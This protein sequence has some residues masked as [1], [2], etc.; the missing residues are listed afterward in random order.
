MRASINRT[1]TDVG[2]LVCDPG[3][4]RVYE[5]GWQSWSPTTT[6]ALHDRPY[7]PADDNLR[8]VNYRADG[9]APEGSFQ[10]E[11]LLAVQEDRGGPVHLLAVRVASPAP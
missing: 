1:F 3:A 9:S 4:A 8:V 5:H 2:E 6:Y 7:R 10:G 11:G